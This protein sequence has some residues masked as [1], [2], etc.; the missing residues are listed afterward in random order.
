MSDIDESISLKL[1]L[2]QPVSIN[3]VNIYSPTLNEIVSVGY[4]TYNYGLS[5]LLFDKNLFEDLKEIKE[6]NFDLMVHFFVKDESFRN[7]VEIGSNLIFKEEIK[8]EIINNAPCFVLGDSLVDHNSLE[9]IQRLIKIANRIPDKKPEDEFNP[10]NSKAKEF[11][12][13]ILGDRA[14]RPPKKPITNLPSIVSGL[15]W[16]SN[17]NILEIGNLTIYQVYDGYY[18]MEN[19]DHYNGILTGIYTGNIDSSKIKLQE[20]A[21]TK[22]ID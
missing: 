10:S 6:S 21:W 9:E 4:D 15:S 7:S 16:K 2:G 8:V 12:D 22:I 14:K 19:I 20:S 5:S 18:R 17:L 11:M 3:G 1:L 13:K